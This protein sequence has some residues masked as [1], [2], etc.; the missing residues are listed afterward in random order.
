M[1][2]QKKNINANIG[3]RVFFRASENE[4]PLLQQI[5]LM[6]KYAAK[7]EYYEVYRLKDH[8]VFKP[9]EVK[10]EHLKQKLA[11]KYQ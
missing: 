4:N 6:E 8:S 9:L 2:K 5:K 10:D 3:K 1:T 7:N 11:G